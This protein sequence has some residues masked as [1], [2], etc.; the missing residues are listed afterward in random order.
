MSALFITDTG[1]L[2]GR[3]LARMAKALRTEGEGEQL[4]ANVNRD[5]LAMALRQVEPR[6]ARRRDRRV[7]EGLVGDDERSSRLT[8]TSTA[9]GDFSKL[10]AY[11]GRLAALEVR[12][13]IVWG[14]K[15]EFAPVGGAHRF[16][17]Q[18][19]GAELVVLDDA[20]HYVMEDDPKRVGEKL[21][22]SSRAL[23]SAERGAQGVFCPRCRA[24][25]RAGQRAGSPN[26]GE[27]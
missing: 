11:D 10:E 5:L 16:H 20:G 13:R 7:L 6:A 4:V 19:P 25:P 1:L 14:A 12:A 2:P 8:S 22:S 21:G 15:D 27:P 18:L 3:A 26:R 17:K 9:P 24:S 23:V